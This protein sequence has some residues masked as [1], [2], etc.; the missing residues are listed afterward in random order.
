[1]EN[2]NKDRRVP[3]VSRVVG[4]TLIELVYDESKRSTALVVSRFGG[5]WNIEQEVRLATTEILVPYSPRNNLIANS[6]VLL[7]SQPVEFGFKGELI[8]EIAAFLHRYVDLS[9]VFEKIAAYYV[10]LTWVYDAFNELPYLRLRG[11]YGTGKTRAL[12]AIGSLC[13]KPFFASGASTSS[14]IF[15]TLD[16]FGGTLV[17]DEADMPFSDAKAD[18][19]KI[20]NNGTVRGMPVLRTIINRYKEFNPYAFRVFGPKI[21]ACRDSFQDPALESR[22]LTE[23]TGTRPLRPDIPIQLPGSLRT[24]AL[25][26]RNKLLHFRLCEFFK[27]KT[28]TTALIAGVEPRINQ[29]ALSLL[30]LVDDPAIRSEIQRALISRYAET[31]VQ[32]QETAEMRVLSATLAEFDA[33]GGSGAPVAAITRRF[34][35]EHENEYGSAMTTRW[36]GHILRNRLRV[37]TH[38]SHGNYVV[39]AVE[40]TMLETLATRYGVERLD[41]LSTPEGDNPSQFAV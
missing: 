12:L 21:I 4:D 41:T 34:N 14:P 7:P 27:I 3:T 23:D 9:P 37:S 31:Q 8:A 26:L 19:V 40:R 22:F 38:K 24:E 36:I 13:Y 10:L 32:R 17:L 2:Q 1:M 15:H 5:L 6:C 39:P 28:D 16:S 35:D 30:S 33:T 11:D 18:L 25:A 20:L 29:T